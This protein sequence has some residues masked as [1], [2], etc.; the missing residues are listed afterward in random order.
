VNGTAPIANFRQI[1]LMTTSRGLAKSCNMRREPGDS[2]LVN[3]SSEAPI[4]LV[5][6]HGAD[7]PMDSQFMNMVAEAIGGTDVR[8][9]RFEFPYMT[10]QRT[11]GKRHLPIANR[12]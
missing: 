3:G 2:L 12:Y 6:A 11:S 10:A 8:V 7:A 4:T 1:S 9:V 5:L